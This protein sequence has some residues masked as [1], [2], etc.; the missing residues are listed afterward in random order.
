MDMIQRS[1]L[2]VNCIK[3]SMIIIQYDDNHIY[4]KFSLGCRL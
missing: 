2:Q 1:V 3:T 4:K